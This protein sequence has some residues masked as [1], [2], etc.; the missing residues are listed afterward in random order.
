MTATN[1]ADRLWEDEKI[2][3]DRRK[4]GLQ[5]I[6]RIGRYTVPVELFGEVIAEL[7]VVVVPEGGELPPQ[8]ELDAQLAAE[9]AATAED[10][11]PELEYLPEV[12][13]ELPAAG[14]LVEDAADVEAEHGGVAESSELAG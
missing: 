2:R 12:E 7:R 8:E 1:V 5:T 14:E 6:K 9:A 3:V 10:A 13:A 11:Q 4:L